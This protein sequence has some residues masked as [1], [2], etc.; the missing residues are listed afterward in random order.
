MTRRQALIGFTLLIL[1]MILIV[2]PGLAAE[3]NKHRPARG[4]VA[5]LL[6]PGLTVGQ[7]DKIRV[8]LVINNTGRSNETIFLDVIET[9]KGWKAYIKGFSNNIVTGIFMPDD[10]NRTL[11]FH[12]EPEGKEKKLPPGK[13]HFVVRAKTRDGALIRTS[14]IDI[15][16]VEQETVKGA[17]RLTTSYPVLRG[18]SD[19]KFEFSLDVNNDSEEDTIFNL[20]SVTPEGWE[21]SFKP[22]YEQ[23]QISSLRIKGNQSQTVGV[24]VTPP[25]AAQ[26]GEYPIKVRIQS[27]K[28][29]AETD[30]TV[31]LT[32]TYKIKLGTLKGLLSLTAQTG[33]ATN[34]SIYVRN[35]GSAPQREV[36][37]VSFKPESWKVEFKPE[38]LKNLKPGEMKQVEVTITTADEALVGDY[39][40]SVKAEGEKSSDNVELRVTVKASAAWGWVG[41]AI[42]LLVI[43][44]LALV[45]RR[46]GRR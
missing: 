5:A 27:A 44:G 21:V 8:D 46:L 30:L 19:I 35:E 12:A 18:P 16:V 24:E 9:P 25:F 20:Q 34:M 39:S 40:V 1:G 32:G 23:K 38:K 15:T 10:S 26:A 36:S 17:V 13:Y 4:L 14:S 33:K 29:K 7:D 22:G 41:V 3:A 11:S 6:Y 43:I 28:D 31:V 42:I 2:G 45:F 37:F